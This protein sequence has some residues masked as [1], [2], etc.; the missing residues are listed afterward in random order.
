M[1]FLEGLGL[2]VVAIA[3]LWGLHEL[4]QLLWQFL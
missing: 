2:G 3:S 4:L 1:N